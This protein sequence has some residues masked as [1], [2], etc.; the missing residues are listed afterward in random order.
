VDHADGGVQL[1]DNKREWISMAYSS[2]A[3]EA[4]IGHIDSPAPPPQGL[5]ARNAAILTAALFPVMA[6]Y[7]FA[8]YQLAI[9]PIFMG[10]LFATYWG[11]LKAMAPLEF[12]PAVCG[13][14]VGIGMAY[15]FYILPIEIGMTGGILG[16]VLLT[17]LLFLLATQ[18]FP[19]FVN[20]SFVVFLTV[21]TIPSVTKEHDFLGM[22]EAVILAAAYFKII[23]FFMGKLMANRH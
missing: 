23:L 19:M 21:A 18:W 4:D 1:N 10:Y 3:T 16:L 5:S 9:A 20:A 17:V 6:L 7:I 14:L 8:G 22:A 12:Y 2:T 11:A 13:A 15:L